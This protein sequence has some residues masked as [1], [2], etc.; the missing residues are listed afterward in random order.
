[1]R[2]I[3]RDMRTYALTR[4]IVLVRFVDELHKRWF[5]WE[6]RKILTSLGVYEKVVGGARQ[7]RKKEVSSWVR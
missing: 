1:M 2:V 5:L 4:G 7:R 3:S 6:R